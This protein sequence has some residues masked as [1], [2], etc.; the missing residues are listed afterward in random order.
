MVAGSPLTGTPASRS[1][2]SRLDASIG[3][4]RS[5]HGVITMPATSRP[6]ARA[7]STVSR[8]WLI[9]P[10]P[11]RAA[12]TSGRPRSTARSRTE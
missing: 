3:S 4:G 7:A 10:S 1:S 12:T 5:G 11:V 6:T 9:V 2:V 8:V